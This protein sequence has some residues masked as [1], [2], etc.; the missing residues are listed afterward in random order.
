MYRMSTIGDVSVMYIWLSFCT[1][2][3]SVMDSGCEF[4]SFACF[5][6]GQSSKSHQLTNQSIELAKEN[7][8]RW[9]RSH[10]CHL[11]RLR[12]VSS[13][14][15][16]H[17]VWRNHNAIILVIRIEQWNLRVMHYNIDSLFVLIGPV[18]TEKSRVEVSLKSR[19]NFEICNMLAES[20]DWENL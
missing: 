1:T 10:C 19:S 12:E 4:V 6:W 8:V 20:K 17:D 16:A 11:E 15:S 13:V 18:F 2:G 9:E 14:M 7:S 3:P 5:F